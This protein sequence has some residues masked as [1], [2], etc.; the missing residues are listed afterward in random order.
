VTLARERQRELLEE[1]A[2]IRVLRE[3]KPVRHAL[4]D[5]LLVGAGDMLVHTGEKLQAL[6]AARNACIE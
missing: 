6:A 1:A 2:R 3:A 5:R 4:A